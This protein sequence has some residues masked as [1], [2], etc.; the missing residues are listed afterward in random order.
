MDRHRQGILLCMVS[1]CGFG[2]MAIFAKEAYAAGVG[3]SALLTVRFVLAAA[4]LW[5]IVGVRGPALPGRRVL[6]MGLAL[7]AV[8]YA[9]E[10]RLFFTAL[11]HIDAS[12]A[13]LLL[14]VYPALVFGGAVALRRER[15]T[16]PKVG[17]LVLATAGTILVL[18]GGGAGALDGLGVALGLAAA[19]TYAAYVLAAHA[20][21]PRSD[22]FVLSAT[23]M[24]GAALTYVVA[25]AV[26]GGIA[27]GFRTTGW[28]MIVAIALASTVLPVG[29]LLL[30]LA[31]VGPSTASIVSTVEPL[32]TVGLAVALF[33][34][35]LAP[36]QLAGGALVLSAVAALQVGGRRSARAA[37]LRAVDAAP[38]RPTGGAAARPLARDA[39]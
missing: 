13:A 19:A 39:A 14:Y 4:V 36:V 15:A 10:A 17:A 29:A 3:A 34:E 37:S 11:E 2:L 12:L 32:V 38:A 27:L 18:A 6:L 24:T 7:G 20:V 22:P 1:A 21:V 31:R 9:A 33:G 16:R 23:I 8:G 30:G 35:A 5:A 26:G 28:A 25:S